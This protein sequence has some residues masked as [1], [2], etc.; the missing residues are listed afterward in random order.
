[1]KPLFVSPG[2]R[3]G[4]HAAVRWVLACSRVRVPEPIRHAEQI[5][6]RF[7]AANATATEWRRA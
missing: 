7:R 1:V 4:V 3:I 5:A 6:T 2:H